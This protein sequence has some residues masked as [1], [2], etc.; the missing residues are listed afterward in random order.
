MEIHENSYEAFT[1]RFDSVL[2]E[3]NILDVKIE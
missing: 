1:D 3:Y 2:T